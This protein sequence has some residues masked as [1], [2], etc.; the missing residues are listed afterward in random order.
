[1]LIPGF[2]VSLSVYLPATLLRTIKFACTSPKYSFKRL[3]WETAV[4]CG[5][6]WDGLAGDAK[7]CV[8][9]SVVFPMSPLDA[10]TEPCFMRSAGFGCVF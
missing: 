10:V 6:T 1:M 7:P 2:M 3:R 8:L 4:F 5:E 9:S